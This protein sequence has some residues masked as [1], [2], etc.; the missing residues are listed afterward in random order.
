MTEKRPTIKDIA[1]IV[2]VS[3][4]TVSMALN[5]RPRIG[6]ETRERILA[7]ARDLNYQP[8]VLARSLATHKTFTIGLIIT[9]ITDP[10][11]PE[12]AKGIED[13][14]FEL[15]YTIILCS[16]NGDLRLER[17]FI[18]V[19]RNKGADGII[20]ATV[21][22]DDP[23]IRPLLAERFPFVL[24]NRRLT[25]PAL[26]RRTDSVVLDNLRGG[27]LAMEHLLRLGHT[28][29]AVVAGSGKV[30]TAIERT[31]GARR[32]ARDYGVRLD[33][34]LILEC[35]FD[36]GL[37]Y[38][39]ARRLL[40]GKRPPTAFFAE[41]DNMALGVR[42]AV[43]DA[44]LRIPEDVA[45]VGFDDIEVAGLRGID[46]TTVS[47]KKYE[48]GSLGV[49]ILVDRLE[50]GAPQLVNRIVLEPELIVRGSCGY[51]ARGY[52]IEKR[53]RR[54]R[55]GLAVACGAAS[56][57]G[58][59][60]PRGARGPKMHIIHSFFLS[61]AGGGAMRR[62]MLS[63]FAVVCAV[64]LAAGTAGAV[65]KAAD[66]TITLKLAHVNPIDSPS[67]ISAKKFVK[68]VAEKT[69]GKVQIKI[70]PNEQLGAE[71]ATVQ[72]VILGTIDIALADA[73]YV[74]DAVHPAFGVTD[75]P[76]T[77]RDWDHYRKFLTSPI[78]K[79]LAKVAE[80]EKNVKPLGLWI[81]GRRMLCSNKPV[82]V[83]EDAKGMKIRTP[84][85][86]LAMEAAR[87]LG[88]VPVAVV[89]GETYMALKQGVADAA[90]NPF[91]GIWDMKWYEV[92]K[93]IGV[94]QHI[95]NNETALMSMKAWKT[96]SPDQ[97]KAVQEAYDAASLSHLDLQMKMEKERLEDLKKAGLTI[98]EPPS[99]APFQKIAAEI[100]KNYEK[101]YE[102]AG[103]KMW[104]DKILA[105]K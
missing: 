68:D 66:G 70:F 94:T 84:P 67:D 30:S 29:I 44:G 47:Q 12:L 52:A 72:G 105:L 82:K 58:G 83:P 7:V 49:R 53:V 76:Y 95:W 24:V 86:E 75:F 20:F 54:G 13:K 100:A 33:P 3:P 90:E 104:R 78:Y 99:L 32:A 87:V 28:R 18:T 92:T 10:F 101:K 91:T 46:L 55:G 34:A 1:R 50:K 41:D 60:R 48:M 89:Y 77:F 63:L 21:E 65:E 8:N 19:L 23:N 26:A 22:A 31:E 61:Q 6:E 37:A 25:D 73:G 62:A 71:K 74:A 2:G 57:P 56:I 4:T 16:T 38:Q 15:G 88:G 43:L 93:Y 69:K 45:L 97:Q 17:H 103:W 80:K 102:K 5:G 51:A 81:F 35:S 59:I 40:S 11:Y 39:A 42:E 79:D 9:S 64:M 98:I 36:K 85:N 14:A 27:Y 96:L